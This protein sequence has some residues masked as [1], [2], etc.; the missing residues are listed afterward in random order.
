MAKWSSL[1]PVCLFSLNSCGLSPD[2]CEE[3]ISSFSGK[4]SGVALATKGGDVTFAGNA[5]CGVV[6]DGKFDFL[7]EIGE[8]WEKSP[9]E[10][11]LRP[12]YIKV[13]GRIDRPKDG[14]KAPILR[15]SKVM[16][17]S[18]SFTEDEAREQFWKRMRSEPPKRHR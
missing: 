15:V 5:E 16:D 4:Y 9:Y 11:V 17:I 12:I 13:A 7:R 2:P 14:A 8:V 18:L 10:G 3:Y 6:V 1:I